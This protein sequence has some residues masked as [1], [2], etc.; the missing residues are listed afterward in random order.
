MWTAA[1]MPRSGPA[2]SN[3]YVTTAAERRQ[4]AAQHV[5]SDPSTQTEA[6]GRVGGREWAAGPS[7]AGQQLPE[8]IGYRL[9]ERGRWR[10]WPQDR[11]YDAG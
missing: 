5:V 2:V 10:A 8:R 7:V 9:G 6:G 1:I 11:L 4:S 3:N